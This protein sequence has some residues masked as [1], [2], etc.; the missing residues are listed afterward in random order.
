MGAR[1]LITE[2]W[3]KRASSRCFDANESSGP[4]WPGFSILTYVISRLESGL[5]KKSDDPERCRFFSGAEL[6]D[7]RDADDACAN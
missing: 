1:V 5:I 4:V 6:P 7:L 2:N 3:Y